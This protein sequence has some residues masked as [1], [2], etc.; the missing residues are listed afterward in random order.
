[1]SL[2]ARHRVA[3]LN[4][5]AG[6]GVWDPDGDLQAIVD[7]HFGGNRVLDDLRLAAF[8]ADVAERCARIPLGHILGG[9][10][11]G[12]LALRVGSGTFIPRQQ[13]LGLVRWVER[14]LRLTEG[15]TVY[16]LCAGVGAIGLALHQA[17]RAR[18]VCV[19]IEATAQAYLQRNIQRLGCPGA[20][21]LLAADI[22]R[23]EAFVADLGRVE[24][25]VANPPYVP[26]EVEL[27]PE[28]AL[29]HPP[30]AIYAGEAGGQLIEASAHLASRLLRRGGVVLI[31]H[32]ESQGEHV[33]TLLRGQGFIEVRQ[34]I[35][36]EFSDATG[37]SVFTVGRKA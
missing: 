12:P 25:V 2:P 24:V 22:T 9:V 4:D 23:P 10:R 1:M 6:A 26:P 7:Q 8:Q 14:N 20:V 37:P 18:V 13:S 31:E 3:A 28:W 27:L 5:L 17:T 32:G 34:C 21:S 30:G 36:D 11:F 35:D 19:E 15:A 16:D 29:H 33:A